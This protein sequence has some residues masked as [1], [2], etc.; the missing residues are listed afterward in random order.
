MIFDFPEMCKSIKALFLREKLY[1]LPINQINIM[2]KIYTV[3]IAVCSLSL[4]NA[5]VSDLGSYVQVTDVSNNGIAVG[6]VSGMAFFKWSEADSGTILAMAG[7]NGVSG[8]ANISA[9]GSVISMALPNPD[10]G[11]NEEAA[12][13]TV[14][15]ESF[16]FLGYLGVISD[17]DTSSAWG[18]SSNGKNIVGFA[19]NGSSKGEG[20]YWK[21]GNVIKALGSTVSTRSSRG[22]DVSADGSVIAGWQDASNGVRQGIIWRNGVQEILKDNDGKVLGE[23]IAI[24]ADGKTVTGK[25]TTSGLG[26]IWNETDGT[27]FITNANPD[28]VTEMTALSD[29]GK[30]AIGISFD[31]MQGLLLGEG[32]IWTKE[33]GKVNLNEYVTSLGYDNLGITFS[34]AT[35]ISPD[36]KYIGG[37]GANFEEGDA[38]GFLIK[39]PGAILGSQEVIASDKIGVYP[40]PVHDFVTIKSADAIESAEVYNTAGQMMFSSNKIVNN[41]INL[42]GLS[43]GLYILKVK[44]SKGLQTVKLLKN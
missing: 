8:N 2:K 40:N 39:L 38:K 21:E 19:W 15:T 22:N 42:S 36:G 26:Y 32:F 12:L 27:T 30:V 3:A 6:N 4:S 29:D 5:Q 43:K 11:D 7:D 14:A 25:T 31:P 1:L 44:T 23:A 20:V 17:N 18:M 10:N 41:K 16:K 33:A 28:Y 24:S 13:Y 37:I 9:D 35:G 34:V